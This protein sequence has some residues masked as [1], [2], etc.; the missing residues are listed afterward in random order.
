MTRHF[1]SQKQFT[2]TS[3]NCSTIF[4]KGIDKLTFSIKIIICEVSLHAWGHG[5]LVTFDSLKESCHL[6]R[7]LCSIHTSFKLL[8]F[9]FDGK[10]LCMKASTKSQSR[11]AGD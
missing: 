6:I 7:R 8:D 11:Q 1:F 10:S 4:K 3:T 5:N 2:L 9:M